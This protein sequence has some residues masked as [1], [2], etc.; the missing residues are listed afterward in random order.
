M[1]VKKLS[2][3]NSPGRTALIWAAIGW[4]CWN[5]A[6]LALAQTVNPDLQEVVKLSQEH[7]DD[8]I[9]T[10]FIRNSGKAY[11]LSA[12]DIIYL[13]HQGV[14]QPVILA[15]QQSVPA[16]PTPAPVQPVVSPAPEPP[17]Q[18]TT[19]YPS[20]PQPPTMPAPIAAPDQSAPPEVSFQYFHDQLAPWGAWIDLPGY[21]PVWK[22]SD[23]V[24]ATSPD[25]RPYY[26]NGQWVDTDNGL[27]WQSDY[28]WGDIPFHY[29]HWMRYPGYGWLWVPDYTWG[30]A[31]V[32]WRHDEFEGAVG[33]A[34]LPPGAI[35]IDGAFMY[36]G[37]RV[38]LDF[39]FGLGE[40]AFVFVDAA[41]FHERIFRW[42]GREWPYH[43]GRE[44]MHEY[45]AHS[46]IRN[47]FRR[48]DHGRFVNE[49]IGRDRMEHM[50]IR[51][52]HA[53]FD[54]R[55]AVGDRDRTAHPGAVGGTPAGA[56]HGG[57]YRPPAGQPAGGNA[58]QH[59]PA[60]QDRNR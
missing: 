21:G 23:A 14:S 42:R 41:H 56:G 47:D 28:T 43:I 35:F 19:E 55:H 34:P 25:W 10:S 38:G 40:D 29:G 49:G 12:D 3:L 15:L 54:E 8:D 17:P 45:Y 13:S 31:W 18:P 20:Q 27:Y 16:I 53:G 1:K 57:V 37:S 5:G 22:P 6:S 7:M 30:P 32:F 52:D 48:D 4:M 50:N 36:R 46:V 51:M 44:R 24:L 9:I 39:D 60:S 58:Q 11:R 2:R 26:D 33:W 59:S